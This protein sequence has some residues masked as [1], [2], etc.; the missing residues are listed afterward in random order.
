MEAEGRVYKPSAPLADN[1]SHPLRL[2]PNGGTIV[3][4]AHGDKFLAT[5]EQVAYSGSNLGAVGKVT[6]VALATTYTGLVLS[7]PIGS[8][9]VL[10]VDHVEA[11][12]SVVFPAACHVGLMT[13]FHATTDVVHTNPMTVLNS[14][15]GGPVGVGKTDDEATLPTTPAVYN[16]FGAVL[17]SAAGSFEHSYGSGLILPPGGFAAIYTSTISGAAALMGSFKWEEISLA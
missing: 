16:I 14:Y 8:G 1:S 11:A 15:I 6:T 17:A 7:N 4:E 10:A 3:Q 2:G 13:G 5:I 9:K 12:F